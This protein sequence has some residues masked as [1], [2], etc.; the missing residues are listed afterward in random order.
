MES[1]NM[2]GLL[3]RDVTASDE[4]L[5]QIEKEEEYKRYIDT[6]VKNVMRAYEELKH[7]NWLNTIYNSDIFEAF[8]QL[9]RDQKILNH[10]ASKYSD[11]EFLA[12]RVRWYPATEEEKANAV[13]DEDWEPYAQAWKRHY[14]YNDHHPEHWI[15]EDGTIKDMPLSCII[16]MIC[17]WM[18]FVYIG[19]GSAVEYW[20]KCKED[21]MKLMSPYTIK[22]VERIID[23]LRK[24]EV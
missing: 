22:Q 4:I 10:D 3:E 20:D 5:S 14:T 16:E 2:F 13:L 1:M 15:G 21:K 17:D 7:N 12:Y 19:K 24:D 23:I 11:A 6:H 18:S 8:D 9:D